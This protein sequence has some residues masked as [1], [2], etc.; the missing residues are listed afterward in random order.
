MMITTAPWTLGQQGGG[1]SLVAV[2]RPVLEALAAPDAAR[3]IRLSAI[4]L[5]PY[6]LGQG[7]RA[8]WSMRAEQVAESAADLQ[9]ITR[10]VVEDATR[11]VVGLA[12]FHG[13]PD[14]KGMVEI[15]YRIDPSRRRRGHARKA[16]RTLIHVATADPRV[17]VIRASVSPDNEASLRL[18]A[19][20]GFAP[21]GEHWDDV[22]GLEIVY[23]ID[24][25][26]RCRP[27]DVR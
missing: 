21:V 1:L 15:G 25:V 12:G 20:F 24:A 10:F 3:A 22:D 27:R 16:V 2:P 14:E 23:E 4:D 6:L 19:A 11:T 17:R 9:W 5:T 7:C 18:I 26:S 8:L 13:R